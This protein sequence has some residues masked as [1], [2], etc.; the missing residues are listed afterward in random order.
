MVPRARDGDGDDVVCEQ[1]PAAKPTDALATDEP[2]ETTP[3]PTATPSPTDTSET[4]FGD[5]TW[6]VGTQISPGTYASSGGDFCY[7]AR[8]SGFS[9]TIDD[10]IANDAGSARSIVTIA[11]G[12]RGFETNGCGIWGPLL[13]VLAPV[14]TIA[15]GTWVVPEE[16]VAGTYASSGGD[17]C[18]WARLSGFSGTIDD[19][20]AND[21]G[22]ARSIVTIAPVDRGFQTNGCGIWRPL[23]EVLAPVS[24]ITDG[25]W[26]VPEEVVAGTYAS[27]GGDFCYW[28]RLS[29]FSGTIDDVIANDVVSARSIVTIAPGD[30]GFQTNGCGIWARA[31]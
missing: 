21:A 3:M 22:S 12:D 24:T 26:V 11:P 17:F 16:V 25:T 30:R 14:S 28:A 1:S 10:V 5:G 23:L 31:S 2:A 8:L 27:S 15:D 13:E 9:G 18:Y 19:V 20:I 4:G 6:F 7:W 29:G